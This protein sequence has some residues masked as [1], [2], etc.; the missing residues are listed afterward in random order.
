MA[1]AFS[2][3]V[4]TVIQPKALPKGTPQFEEKRTSLLEAFAKKVP[5]EL[6]LPSD[7]FVNPPIDVSKVPTTCG[8]LSRSEV[9]ITE[10][11]DAVGL[12]EAIAARKFTSLE[13]TTAFCKRSIIAHQLTCCLTQWFMP[14]ALEQ[15]K[16]LDSYLE[17]HGKTK[18]PFHGV[19]ISIKEHL[20]MAG[21]YSSYGSFASTQFDEKDCLM[22]SL[23]RDMGAVFYCKTNQPQLI[24]HLESTSHYGRT[25]NPFNTNLSAGGSSGGEGAL[26]AM[27]GSVLG[28]GT[29]I[30]GSIRGPS[31]FNG[32]YGFKPTSYTLPAK[33]FISHAF[34]AELNILATGG[35]M[36]RS[37]RDTD[38]FMSTIL[39][40]KPYIHDQKLVP[41]TWTGLKT[42]TRKPLKI[43]IIYNDG[44]IY[45]QPPVKRAIAWACNQLED[46]KYSDIFQVKSF[47][48]YNAAEAWSKARRMYWPSGGKLARADVE[49][50][51][52]PVLPLS[53]WTWADAAP[54]GMLDAEQV[55]EMRG[56]RDAFRYAFADSWNE[57]DVDIVIGPAFVG[58]ACSHDTAFYWTYTSL[59]N[60]VDYP[61]IVV[62]TPIKAKKGEQ[63]DADYKPLGDACKHVKQLWEEGDFEGAPIDLQINAR[64][65]H[66]NE[67][68]GAL[69]MLKD[70]LKLP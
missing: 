24:M 36:C 33:G 30:G 56:E 59:W 40:T 66:D 31:A 5:S 37:L 57:Q 50:T 28:V 3:S 26:V 68:F 46:P 70:V 18:G 47:K 12:A 63:Y 29:D 27:K 16:E 65:Y 1:I 38:F 14:E 41:M 69:A 60:F 42:A 6:R 34:S 11:Y 53:E 35:S 10:N 13:V 32:I 23:L 15:A 25:L 17:K 49:S 20:P 58:P 8:I 9:D 51:G 4:L 67:L 2:N 21:T 61:G 43:G 7:F 62:P 64:R 54:H 22:V 48:P 45:P 44:Y 39:G 19:P 55:N 52:E